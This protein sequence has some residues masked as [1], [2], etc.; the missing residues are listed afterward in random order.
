MKLSVVVV[1]Q[2]GETDFLDRALNSIHFDLTFAVNDFEMIVVDNRTGDGA[3]EIIDAFAQK[4]K[5]VKVIHRSTRLYPHNCAKEAYETA[6]G[7]VKNYVVTRDW[8]EMNGWKLE[9]GVMVETNPKGCEYRFGIDKIL[10]AVNAE[11]L[12]E[13]CSPEYIARE[14]WL[15]KETEMV[16]QQEKCGMLRLLP[17][18]YGC[19][20]EPWKL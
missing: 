14:A 2:G 19:L 12:N 11:A 9:N 3:S 18:T 10:G 4:H 8:G 20:S 1:V 7:D 6:E 5:D 17:K 13:V 15:K 16:I